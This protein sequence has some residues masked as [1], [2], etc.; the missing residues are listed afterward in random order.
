MAYPIRSR[1]RRSS[2]GANPVESRYFTELSPAAMQYYTSATVSPDTITMDVYPKDGNTGLP[3]GAPAVTNNVWQTIS[4]PFAGSISEWGKNGAN[5]F[6]GFMANI[7]ATVGGEL[8]LTGDLAQSGTSSDY[9][10]FTA[11]GGPKAEFFTKD[12]SGNWLGGEINEVPGFESQGDWVLDAGV[13]ISGGDLVFGSGTTSASLIG[14]L[15]AA[16]TYRMEF[17]LS[18]FAS[19][20][21]GISSTTVSGGVYSTD[22]SGE[23]VVTKPDGALSSNFRLVSTAGGN[24]ITSASVKKFLEVK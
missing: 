8:V 18:A 4:F 3:A 7:R 6:D 21:V 15:G 19:G 10:A 9:G 24:R 1:R 2:G 22:L 16:N 23:V 14:V 13:T 11:I 17:R 5:Y 20:L 12:E